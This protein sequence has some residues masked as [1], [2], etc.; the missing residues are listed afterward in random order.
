MLR[1]RSEVLKAF[2]NYKRR[3]EKETDHSIKHLRTNN[4]KEYLSKKFTSYLE[5][6]GISR[7]LSV[8]YTL[9]QNGVAERANSTPLVEMARCMMLQTKLPKLL[10]AEAVNAALYVY[11]K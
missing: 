5:E 11:T 2:K 9:Q 1:N 10:W 7:Q 4:G 6:E 8:E 3:V